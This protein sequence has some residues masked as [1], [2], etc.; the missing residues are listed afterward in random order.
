MSKS[1]TILIIGM[2][3]NLLTAGAQETPSL[4]DDLKALRGGQWRRPA[5]KGPDWVRLVVSNP[6]KG[7]FSFWVWV[8]PD[9]QAKEKPRQG[10]TS[11]AVLQEEKTNRFIYYGDDKNKIS[12]QFKGSKLILTGKYTNGSP[13][14]KVP[15]LSGEWV[16]VDSP[17]KKQQK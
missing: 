7:G 3:S 2:V 9:Q 1:I 5:D 4:K 10:F 13:P 14:R 16:K 12:Y 11:G 17:K 6:A 8:Y 15:D